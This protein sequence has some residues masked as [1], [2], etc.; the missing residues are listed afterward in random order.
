MCKSKT[1]C[2]S[3]IKCKACKAKARNKRKGSIYNLKNRLSSSKTKAVPFDTFHP[4]N[5]T[6]K[7][8]FLEFLYFLIYF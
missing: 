2:K 5:D 8:K 6:K 3:K 7:K 4:E 1:K